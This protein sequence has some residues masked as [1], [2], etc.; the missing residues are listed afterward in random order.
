MGVCVC[1][2]VCVYERERERERTCN[3]VRAEEVK[4]PN[5]C[6]CSSKNRRVP[7]IEYIES[8]MKK[9]KKVFKTG[10]IVH[11][12]A[13]TCLFSNTVSHISLNI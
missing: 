8:T 9:I 12:I 1:E 10:M 7:K 11:E 2:R 5:R 4:L 13:L 6:G 3:I